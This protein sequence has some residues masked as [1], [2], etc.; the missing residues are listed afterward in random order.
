MQLEV[1]LGE[2]GLA[3]ELDPEFIAEA[4]DFFARIDADMDEGWQV[5]RE[6]VEQPDATQRCQVVADKLLTALENRDELMIKL[7]AGY[8]LDRLPGVVGVSIDGQGELQETRFHTTPQR[9]D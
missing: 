1:Y 3:I 8:I 4:K 7:T 2:G 9:G 6:W 5:G